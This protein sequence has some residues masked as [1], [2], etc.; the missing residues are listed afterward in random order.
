MRRLLLLPTRKLSMKNSSPKFSSRDLQKSK[1]TLR[2]KFNLHLSHT[3]WLVVSKNSRSFLK[4]K[5]TQSQF[6]LLWEGSVL[7]YQSMSRRTSTILMSWSMSNSTDKESFY[8]TDPL[9]LWRFNFSSQKIS[10]HISNLTQ[11]SVTFRGW[12]LLK[13]GLSSGLTDQSW[14]LATDILCA[15]MMRMLQRTSLKSL[16]CVFQ[17]EWRAP[18][19]FSQWSSTSYAASLFQPLLSTLLWSTLGTSLTSRL[20]EPRSRWRTTVYCHS[21]SPSWDYP[22]RS[23]SQRMEA[24]AIFCRVRNIC[25][26]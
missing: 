10:S 9:T 26:Q 11:R 16:P 15:K 12:A 1:L 5:T 4:I 3:S 18:T 6:H 19:K 22:R 2:Q 14:L 20:R 25:S 8:T 21:S 7:M 13:S 23:P 17:S 24:Q